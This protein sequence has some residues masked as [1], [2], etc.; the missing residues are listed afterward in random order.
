MAGGTVTSVS[1]LNNLA[2]Q[3]RLEAKDLNLNP[4]LAQHDQT[5]QFSLEPVQGQVNL[6]GTLAGLFNQNQQPLTIPVTVQKANLTS[7]EQTLTAQGNVTLGNLAQRPALTTVNLNVTNGLNLAQLPINALLTQ[8]PLAPEFRP[9]AMDLVGT[10]QFTGQLTGK[11]VTEVGQLKLAGNVQVNNL[12]VN[13]YAF[14][15][16]LKGP[17][18]LQL[19]KDLLVNLQGE[20]DRLAVNLQPCRGDCLLPYLPTSFNLR[21]AY[22]R[23]QP[24]LVQGKLSGDQLAMT[25]EHFPLALLA[26]RPG[27][28][29]Q[30]PGQLDG[31]F[32]ANLVVNLRNGHGQGDLDIAMVKLGKTAIGDVSAQLAYQNQILQLKQAQVAT[33]AGTYQAQGSLN[34]KTEAIQAR[35]SVD[36]AQINPLLGALQISDIGSLLR[37]AKLEGIPNDKAEEI[38]G[39]SVG[40]PDVALEN[41]LNLL[42]VIDQQIIALAQK[43]DQGGAPSELNIRGNFDG[44]IELGGTLRKPSLGVNFEGNQLSWYPQGPFP[45]IVPPLGVVMN[46][47]RFLPIQRFKLQ[48][49][50]ADGQLAL[51]PSFVEIRE[52]RLGV[53]GILSPEKSRLDWFVRDFNL[54]NLDSFFRTPD[55]ANARLNG[56]GA[57][58]LTATGPHLW[59]KFNLDE[60]VLNARP[61]PEQLG[62]DFN[63]QDNLLQLVTSEN[64]PLYL[65]ADVPFAWN[66]QKA[67]MAKEARTFG[68]ELKIPSDSFEL[69]SLIS[70][71]QLVWLGGEGDVNLN[72]EGEIDQQNGVAIRDLRALGKVTLT[73]ANIKSAA[74]P[75]PVLVDGEILFNNTA[76]AI[77]QLTGQLDQS[78]I[79]IAGVLP[80][81]DPQPGLENPLQISIKPTNI[82]IPNLYQGDL[83]G[84][85]T[86]EGAV[87]KPEISGD[88]ALADGQVFV[89]VRDDEQQPSRLAEIRTSLGWF[90]GQASTPIIEPQLK[91]LRITLKNLYINQDP[92]YTFSFGGGLVVNGPLLNFN[93]L[94]GDGTISLNRGRVS[95][96]DTR[97]L[98]DRRSPNTITFYSD[99][100]LLNP[101]LNIAM[102]TIVSDLPQSARMRSQETNEYPDDSLN[103]IQR[104]DVRLTIE[105]SLSQILPNLNPRYSAVCDPTVTFRP[106]TGVG[107]FD[108]YQLDR[109]S[110]C[111]QIL[112]AQGVE[113]EQIFS[114]P[115]L[116]LTSSP[117]R[118]EGEIVRLLGEQVIVLVDAL[119][120]KNSSQLLQVG[121]TQLAIPM[122]FQGLVYDV[123]NAI[124]EK[125]KS[126]DFRV[127]PFLE[128]IYEVENKGYM[129][130]TYDYNLSQFIIRYEK[131]F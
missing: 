91:D 77:E 83:S 111:L 127:V 42:Y 2:W 26:L 76:I 104:I 33:T 11:N 130:F 128:A 39:L 84:L 51:L 14:E 129:R 32:N 118:T 27:R 5:S 53:E 19:N 101:D 59:G 54:N 30:I 117:P 47:T 6:A 37:F 72:V 22:N 12:A 34:F 50:F 63:Y 45:N 85:F 57:L 96:F 48:A 125:I 105:G 122:I 75:T 7:G 56:S 61:I 36:D 87:L 92:I 1:N 126:T 80:L 70:Q 69:L 97:F 67:T 93:D 74:L 94:R 58:E 40:N 49:K 10:S 116:S 124:G 55:Q 9:A 68:V 107:S 112:A 113:N 131:Q 106:L 81:F 46:E 65:R 120:G 8:L 82:S 20:S 52:S 102:R 43:Y 29:Y 4:L 108:E 15:P 103:Q 71:E 60:I 38:G 21:Q 44:A 13:S 64:S 17:L 73:G 114:N 89:P 35:I 99:Q 88:V 28:R 62:G 3:S 100:D 90:K 16:Q 109:L 66:P 41:Q 121:I 79:E 18:S 86:I 110:R 23:E 115:A 78:R 98:L 119:Q 123:E 24:I 31:D 95:F 25:V